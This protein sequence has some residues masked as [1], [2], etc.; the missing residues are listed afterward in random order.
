MAKREVQCAVTAHRD[1]ADAAIGAARRDAVARLNAGQ[2]FANQ[3]IFV[4]DLAIA[5]IDVKRGTGIGSDN[6]KFAN[7]I[8][9]PQILHQIECAAV[10]EHLIVVA[11]S[12]E[13][14]QDGELASFVDVVAG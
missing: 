5:R 13:K 6:Q 10:N 3:K 9:F 7:L 12:V 2:K 14:I 8:A 1:S 4:M 11:E